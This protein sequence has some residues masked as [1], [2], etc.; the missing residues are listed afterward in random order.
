VPATWQTH[1]TE[2]SIPAGAPADAIF[3]LIAD[4][5]QWPEMFG[6]TVHVE[7]LHERPPEQLLRI[8]AFA[9]GQVRSWTSQ[10][11]LDPRRH[12]ICFQQVVSAHP[13]AAMGGEWLI[14]PAGEQR[15]TVVLKH[16]FQAVDD[17][18]E[19][20]R[21]IETAVDHNSEAELAALARTAG[22]G[23]PSSGLRFGFTDTERI[24]G[25][26]E[27]VFQFLHRAGQWP[28]L[29][30]HVARLELTEGTLDDGTVQQHMEMDTRGPDGSVHTTTSVRLSFADRHTIVYKQLRVPPVMSAHTGGWSVVS[31][32]AWLAATAWHTVVLDPAGVRDALGPQAT[33]AE[34]RQ[35]VR[36]ALG[37]NSLTTL[38]HAKA[39]AEA[40]HV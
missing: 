9:N 6:P 16:Q 17:D 15:S 36:R 20:V 19:A 25:R 3:A 32:G 27:D 39:Y 10:R 1:L 22:Q 35:K 12:S 13:V 37:G 7:V 34:A 8:W 31:E 30:P 40:S 14:H 26:A 28:D 33:L 23:G 21:L 2:H 29:L 18:P 11:T 4:V 5:T 24:E 38:R